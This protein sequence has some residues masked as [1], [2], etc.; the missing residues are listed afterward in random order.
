MSK[1]RAQYICIPLFLLAILISNLFLLASV[2]YNNSFFYY[3]K[4]EKEFTEAPLILKVDSLNIAFGNNKI[5]INKYK[6]QSL[7]ALSFYPEL[8]D[9]EKSI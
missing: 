3:C 1:H 7:I 5:L 8:K 9:V 4:S 6:I 2:E